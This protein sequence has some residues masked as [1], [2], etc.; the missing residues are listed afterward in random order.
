MTK[1]AATICQVLHTLN[2]GGGEMLAARLA[3]QLGDRFRFIFMCLEE[4]G[5]LGEELRREGFPVWSVERRPG[6]DWRCTWRLAKL[7][8]QERVDLLHVH[9]YTPFF[10]GILARLLYRRPPVLFTEHGRGFPDY[11]RRKRI[12]ANRLLLQRRDRVV[13]VGEAVRQAL[14]RNEGLPA[15]RVGVIYNGIDLTPFDNGAPP[16]AAVRRDMGVGEKDLVI[17]QVARLDYL[18][19]HCTAIRTLEQ[20]IRQ[21]PEARLVLVGEGPELG[22]IQ[23]EVAQRN[24][25]A[26]VRLLGL[27]KD[28]ARLLSAA[29]VFLLTSISEGI[30]LAVIEALAAGLPVVSTNVGGIG[31]VVEDGRSALLAPSGDHVALAERVLRL[32]GDP[33]LSQQLAKQGRARAEEMFSEKQMHEQ[34]VRLYN[35]MLRL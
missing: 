12:V 35:E 29:D 2:V 30:P 21:R 6:I 15:R 31:E 7:L 33:V 23:Q 28:I 32:V 9:Q 4:V 8:R 19:D 10:Y 17:L 1:H 11:P 34:Y 3:R 20:V 13:G 16:R 25:A 26:S 24:L 27:R 14:I 18:K 22:K 5:T